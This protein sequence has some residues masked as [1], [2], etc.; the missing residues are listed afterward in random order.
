MEVSEEE[1]VAANEADTDA[2]FD[3]LSLAVIES[4]GLL[5]LDTEGVEEALGDCDILRHDVAEFV[6]VVDNVARL[7]GGTVGKADKVF[8]DV[9]QAETDTERVSVPL[10]ETEKDALDDGV[11][12]LENDAVTEADVDAVLERLAPTVIELLE[13]LELDIEGDEETLEACDTLG[14]VDAEVLGLAD[15]VAGMLAGT[16]GRADKVFDD[17]SQADMDT[18]RVSVPLEDT[19]KDT[20]GD[21]VS[22]LERDTVT[23]ADTDAVFEGLTLT[24]T[25]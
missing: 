20:L 12:E 25:E 13:L 17:V 3:E 1:N 10:E 5:E 19:E 18:E 8:E 24:V 21:G 7:L 16:V 22:E 15:N 6:E 23:E 11:S 9:S 2:V 4:L 14:H